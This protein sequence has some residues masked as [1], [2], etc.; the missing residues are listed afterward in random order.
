MLMRGHRET[1]E[2]LEKWQKTVHLRHIARSAVHVSR[3][4]TQDLRKM[5]GVHTE[6]STIQVRRLLWAKNWLREATYPEKERTRA[7][8]AMRAMVFGR[9]SRFVRQFLEDLDDFRRFVCKA[10]EEDRALKDARTAAGVLGIDLPRENSSRD[11][12]W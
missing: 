8:E 4:R 9:P 2:T 1:V 5:L 12:K 10:E 6:V 3:E 11:Q 7:G